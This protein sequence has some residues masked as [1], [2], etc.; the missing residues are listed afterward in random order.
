MRAK[1]RHYYRGIASTAY[2][3]P[4]V[5][6]TPLTDETINDNSYQQNCSTKLKRVDTERSSINPLQIE[7]HKHERDNWAFR[8]ASKKEPLRKELKVTR[9]SY[10][11]HKTR[12]DPDS[13]QAIPNFK[14][15]TGNVKSLT[16]ISITYIMAYTL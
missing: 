7:L 5:I 3:F 12:P 10:R 15:R 6:V 11:K 8:C 9:K 16:I 13:K 2:I 1:P 4:S 14:L